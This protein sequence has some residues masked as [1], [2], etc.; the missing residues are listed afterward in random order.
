M[1]YAD[2]IGVPYVLF[3]GEDEAKAGAVS[4]KDM[5][6]GQQQT[7]PVADAIAFIKAGI[8]E[9]NRGAVIIEK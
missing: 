8:E 3:L 5:T 7:L 9:R 4:V 6:S 2:K 1:N